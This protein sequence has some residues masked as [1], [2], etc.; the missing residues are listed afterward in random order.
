MHAGDDEAALIA[1]VK[2]SV[3]LGNHLAAAGGIDGLV[4]RAKHAEQ[5]L[6]ENLCRVTHRI[7]DLFVARRHAVERTM[8]LDVIEGHSLRFEKARQCPDLID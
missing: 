7:R 1:V 4:Q 6:L 2:V 3:E 8:R 5:R